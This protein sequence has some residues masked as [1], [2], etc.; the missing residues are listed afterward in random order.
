MKVI[1]SIDFYHE[2][3]QNAKDKSIVRGNSP[4]LA[5]RRVM[6]FLSTL[7]CALLL[8]GVIISLHACRTDKSQ[9]TTTMGAAK[10][11]T[12]TAAQPTDR[13]QKITINGVPLAIEIAQTDDARERGLMFREKLP[14][15]QGMLFVFPAAEIQSF[16][17]RNTFIPLDIAFISNDG[18]IVDIQQMKPVDESV[19]YTSSAPAL[20]ALEVNAGWFERHGIA[21]GATVTF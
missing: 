1:E 9:R 7:A 18:V 16:W 11:S 20:Y 10:D 6:T 3:I 2:K 17:M 8:A 14:Q 21:I 5:M 19:L 15:D 13:L 12:D 4:S